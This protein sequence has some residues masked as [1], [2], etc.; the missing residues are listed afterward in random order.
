MTNKASVVLPGALTPPLCNIVLFVVLTETRGWLC[1]APRE[2]KQ[3]FLALYTGVY[4]H[5]IN[6]K[7]TVK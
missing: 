1:T 2:K 4:D 6:T 3:S 7:Y 5:G